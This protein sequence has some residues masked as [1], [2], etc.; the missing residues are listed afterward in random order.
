MPGAPF[1]VTSD[2]CGSMLA[3]GASC[4]LTLTYTPSGTSAQSGTFFV[5]YSDSTGG[6]LG[7][8]KPL[9]GTPT[10]GA[11]LV[12]SSCCGGGGGGGSG[13]GPPTFDFGTTGQPQ[14]RSVTV[15]NVGGADAT[16][17]ALSGLTAP[18]S[19]TNNGCG[20]TLAR[21]S[22]CTATVVFTP[23]GNGTASATLTATYQGG[24]APADAIFTG[25]STTRALLVTTECQGCGGGDTDF[26]TSGT[27][28][29]RTLYVYNAGGATTTMLSLGGVASPFSLSANTCGA[30]LAPGSA[31][32]VSVTFTPPAGSSMAYSGRLDVTYSDAAGALPVVSRGLTATAIDRALVLVTDCPECGSSQGQGVYDFGT[33]GQP[34]SSTFVVKNLGSRDATALSVGSL[35]APFSVASTTCA[36]TLAAGT[37]CSVTV[38]FTPSGSSQ[39]T[40]TLSVLYSDTAGTRPDATRALSGTSTNRALLSMTECTSCGG[41]GGG[42]EGIPTTDFGTSGQPVQ[43]QIFVVNS[44][45][46]AATMVAFTAGAPF[47]VADGCGGTLAAGATCSITVTFTPSG[48][49]T[50]NVQLS[51]S[52]R[53]TAGTLPSVPRNLSGT[54]VDRA[55]LTIIDC[56]FCGGGGGGGG[57]PP[58]PYDFGVTGLSRTQTFTIR[59]QGFRPTTTLSATALTAPFS[60]VPI[61]CPAALAPGSSCRIGVSFTPSGAATSTATLRITYA[62]S[63]G[64]LPDATRALTATSTDRALL[65]VSDCQNCGGGGGGGGG[66]PTTDFGVTGQPVTRTIY[67]FNTGGAATT[68]LSV[69]GLSAT[70][71]SAGTGCPAV[72]ARG[73]GCSFD[74]TFT[75]SGDG[76]A[77]ATLSL[78]YSDAAGA[79][80]S[81]TRTLSG[82]S[83]SHALLQVSD[84]Q[85]CGGGGGG[86]GGIPTTDFGVSGQPVTRTLYVTNRGAVPTVSIAVSGLSSTLFSASGGCSGALAPN[87]TCSFSVTFTP[88]GSGAASATLSLDYADA[89]GMRPSVLQGLAGTS[90]SRALLTLQDCAMCGGGGGGFGTPPPYDFGTTGTPKSNGFVLR[91]TGAL[92]ATLGTIGG[93]AGTPFSASGCPATLPAGQSCTLNVTFSPTAD[94]TF[95]ATMSIPYSDTGGMLPPVTRALTGTGNTRAS[96]VIQDGCCG[97]NPPPGSP[98][99][100]GTWGVPI[101]HRFIIQNQGGSPTTMLSLSVPPPFSISTTFN[102]CTNM[103]PT[104]GMCEVDVVFSGAASGSQALQVVATDS[105]GVRPAVTRDLTA[106]ATAQPLVVILD[107]TQ[108]PQPGSMQS[109]PASYG[110]VGTPR[111]RTFSVFNIGGADVTNLG[112]AMPPGAQFDFGTPGY[113]GGGTCGASLPRSATSGCT[114][115]MTFTPPSGSTATFNGTLALSYGAASTATRAVTATATNRALLVLQ[116]NTCGEGC[117]PLGFAPASMSMPS[118]RFVRLENNGA[119]TADMIV[120]TLPSPFSIDPTG[121]NCGMTLAAGTSCNLT[122]EFRPSTSGNFMGQLNVTYRDTLGA[123]PSLMRT[124]EGMGL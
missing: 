29:T 113:P 95:S 114:V 101:A 69:S 70:R 90:T 11:L 77:T 123:L 102:S 91:N 16:N 81:H 28:L 93:L 56:D 66:I 5:G 64:A 96:I 31:C 83:T 35:A 15:T 97:G 2:R 109:G 25:T 104:N 49:G 36:A 46:Q 62:D 85:F 26:G 103:L 22:S 48:A 39:A 89:S 119:L 75:P 47:S 4:D 45:A 84:C 9:M 42:G 111:A 55:L 57:G 99:D 117:Q 6:G 10:S 65:Q 88:S 115:V 3:A 63:G 13:G 80:P 32:S 14:S 71:F 60:I 86:G 37:S 106:T 98:Y 44:G 54:S 110:T 41:F 73:M 58:P 122:L 118:T 61:D 51:L 52:Y 108:T 1:A 105:Q 50:A 82:T 53:D 12:I 124:L 34:R 76:P 74:V 18:F 67:V 30:T 107:D 112:L 78:D 7:V 24:G 59:N 121:S 87:A 23:A 33:S 94:G 21:G 17:L 38:T 27:P 68:A 100:Y 79:L 19:L 40:A 92:T 8:S 116:D 43:R 20:A 72:L 120:P